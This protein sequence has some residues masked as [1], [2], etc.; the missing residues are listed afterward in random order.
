[1]SIKENLQKIKSVLP[2]HVTLI[3]VSKT[4]PIELIKEAYEAGQRDFGE[5]YIQELENKHKQ[6]PTD[7]RWH[8]IGHLQSN[9]VKYIAPFVYLIH[10]IDSLKLLQEIN[11]QALKNSRTINCLLQIYIA[12]EETKFGFS[13][14]ECE[15][16]FQSEELKRLHNINIIGFMG[17]ATNT[18][19]EIQ[20]R[21]EFRSL[22][23]F[24][25]KTSLLN[26]H[27]TILSMGM[28][29]DYKI[30]IEEG[31]TMIRI[32]SLIFGDRVYNK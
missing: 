25:D 6:F 11:K 20:I 2:T 8:A 13:F 3:A 30:A 19:N 4:K 29:S 9:K 26:P 17:M 1:M 16:L 15:D 23:N 10:G 14:E 7:I 21:N 18:D 28:S 32:G 5:N 24:F 27:I 31:S 22:K 12:K